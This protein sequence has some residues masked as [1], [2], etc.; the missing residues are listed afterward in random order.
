MSIYDE[1]KEQLNSIEKEKE[2]VKTDLADV[3]LFL[4]INL[5]GIKKSIIL[6]NKYK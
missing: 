4:F 6:T 5:L 2:K 3:C 1:M